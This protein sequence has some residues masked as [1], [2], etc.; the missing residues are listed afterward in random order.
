M[1]LSTFRGAPRAEHTTY[2][3]DT[4]GRVVRSS[5]YRE[6]EW[7]DI[8]RAAALALA[9]LEAGLCP[10]GCGQPAQVSWDDENDGRFE[11]NTDVT[12]YARRAL[13]EW[14]RADGKQVNAGVLPSIEYHPPPTD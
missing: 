13:D 1:P 14:A 3:Y 4:D 6:A 2:Q 9:H 7:T 11:V 10:C 5:T 12:C 8:D